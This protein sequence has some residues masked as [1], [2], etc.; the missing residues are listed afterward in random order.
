MVCLQN[1]FKPQSHTK[2]SKYHPLSRYT[3][4]KCFFKKHNTKSCF[5]L[6]NYRYGA[7]EKPPF[8]YLWGT[9]LPESCHQLWIWYIPNVGWRYMCPCNPTNMIAELIAMLA[10]CTWRNFDWKNKIHLHGQHIKFRQETGK[11]KLI[12][13]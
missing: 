3:T 7:F 2:P 1:I 12:P 4:S 9:D 10:P 6:Q 13:I 5:P 11:Y 8:L